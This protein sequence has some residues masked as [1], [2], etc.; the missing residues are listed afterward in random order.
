MWPDN[1]SFVQRFEVSL[2]DDGSRMI[3][4]WEKALKAGEREYDSNLEYTRI[5]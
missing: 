2:S 4:H 3:G 5:D 1:P